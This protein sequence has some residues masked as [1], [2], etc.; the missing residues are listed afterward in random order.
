MQGNVVGLVE[1]VLVKFKDE[2]LACV[3]DMVS[4]L[5]KEQVVD[6][7]GT[8]H[9]PTPGVDE[10][11]VPANHTSHNPDANANTIRNVLCNDETFTPRKEDDVGSRYVPFDPV[12]DTCAPS[13]HSETSTRKNAFQRSLGNGAQH[14]QPLMITDEPTFSLGLTQEEQIQPDAHVMA[15]EVGRGEPMSDNNG[16]DNIE[17]G[18]GS[19]KSKKQKTVPSGLLDDY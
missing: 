9:I 12:S 15:T 4:A 1:S 14:R 6:R 5:C 2:M 19:L 3:K 11:S 18:R 17:E 8:H 10:V 16:D 13:A 7:N